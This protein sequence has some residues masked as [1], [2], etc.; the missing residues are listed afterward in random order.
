MTR[1]IISSKSNG[2]LMLVILAGLALVSIGGLIYNLK[3]SVE[4]SDPMINVIMAIGC[5]IILVLTLISFNGLFTIEPNEAC[6]LILFGSYKGTV[7]E[8][9]FWWVN[10]LNTK[11]KLSLRARNF[12]SERL[13]VNDKSG[14]PIEIS[15]VIVWRVKDTAQATFDVDHLVEYVHVQ[16]ESAVRHLATSYPYDDVEGEELSLRSSMDEISDALGREIQDRIAA[17]GVVI[18]EARINHLAYAPEIAQAML[19]RQQAEAIIA[20]RMKIVDGAVGMVEMALDKL[21]E[22]NVLELDEERKAAMVS[23]LLV[24]LCGD[25]STQP[26]VNAGSL[27]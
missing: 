25:H 21:S 12:D 1:E 26:V 15:A 8:P 10:P 7:R 19:Q 27:Y 9:G 11:K 4:I 5:L 18:D 24:V 22:K 3:T 16:S 20:A 6:V 14:N 2:W 13:K 23:N 17:A